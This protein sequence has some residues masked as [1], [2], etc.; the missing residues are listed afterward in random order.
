MARY[1]IMKFV[2]HSRESRCSVFSWRCRSL[3]PPL[4]DCVTAPHWKELYTAADIAACINRVTPVGY[5]Q[6]LVSKTQL[7][8]LLFDVTERNLDVWQTHWWRFLLIL[9]ITSSSCQ[10]HI[11]WFAVHSQLMYLI[12]FRAQSCLPTT[13]FVLFAEHLW[14]FDVNSCQLWL[15]SRQLQLDH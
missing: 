8:R 7:H 9:L 6:I 14:K 2:L 15:L 10:V 12:R 13:F 5:D 11:T 3:P 1:S 4:K